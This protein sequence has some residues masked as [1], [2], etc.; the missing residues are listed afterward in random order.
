MAYLGSNI[1]LPAGEIYVSMT[2]RTDWYDFIRGTANATQDGTLWVEQSFDP[3]AETSPSSAV[4]DYSHA[5]AVTAASS[6][7]S[8]ANTT[9]SSKGVVFDDPVYGSFW[10]LR[11]KATAS[12]NADIRVHARLCGFG[13][14]G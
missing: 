13:K 12:S 10:R 9:T 4:W 3:L 7:T 2:K 11:F 14:F 5:I 1:T 6:S 8:T